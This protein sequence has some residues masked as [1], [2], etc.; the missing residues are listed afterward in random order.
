MFLGTFQGPVVSAALAADVT[1]VTILQA[2]DWG[3]VPTSARYFFA[4]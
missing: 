4:T 1:L 2:G 3:R